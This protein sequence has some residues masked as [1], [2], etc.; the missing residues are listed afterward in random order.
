MESMPVWLQHVMR[1]LSPTPH[2]VAFSQ[3]LL[4]R[5]ADFSIVWP[6]LVAISW[7]H[8]TQITLVKSWPNCY[9]F[10]N[11]ATMAKSLSAQDSADVAAYFAA[12][13]EGLPAIGGNRVPESGR[14]LREADPGHRLV[15][16]G[17]PQRGIPPCSAGNRHDASEQRSPA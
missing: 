10:S 9:D 6:W 2:F 4:Y 12:Q 1:V 17:D 11:S 14:S 7:G 15:F 8:A 5:G 16:A 3:A 13:R